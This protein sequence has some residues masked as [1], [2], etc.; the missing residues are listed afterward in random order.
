MRIFR[1]EQI[2]L[3]IGFKEYRKLC[4][5]LAIS[6]LFHVYWVQIARK[7]NFGEDWFRIHGVIV[8][9]N[10]RQNSILEIFTFDSRQDTHS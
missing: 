6:W 3:N 1:S 7:S 9:T 4:I 8:Q 2:P 10:F 5:P